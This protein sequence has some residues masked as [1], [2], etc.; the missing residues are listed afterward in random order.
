VA[1]ELELPKLLEG[2]GEAYPD[3]GTGAGVRVRGAV[4]MLLGLSIDEPVMMLTE[5]PELEGR[6]E[7]GVA[8]DS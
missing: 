4:T 7:T 6:V 1:D 3:E 5:K 2:G 8:N